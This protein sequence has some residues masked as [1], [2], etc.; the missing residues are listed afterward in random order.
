MKPDPNKPS[1]LIATPCFGGN[2][3]YQYTQSLAETITRC[4]LA[5]QPHGCYFLANESLIGRGR[6]RCAHIALSR[7]IDKL[8]FIDADIGWS[9]ADVERLLKSKKSVVGGVYPLKKYPI[10]LAMNALPEHE[11]VFPH[12]ERTTTQLAELGKQF[13]NERGEVEVRHIPTGF[14]LIDCSVFEKLKKH[15][16]SYV[17]REQGKEDTVMWD[18]FPSGVNTDDGG[19]E[20][21]DWAFCSLVRK[22]LDCGVWV[23]AKTVLTHTGTHTFLPGWL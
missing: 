16:P 15:V 17:V 22:H 20:S 23:N 18:F 5:R 9:F 10:E 12:R 6:N 13:G 11:E 8:L 21:E 14:M 4:M 2:I 3:T 7:G 19:Y 1:I